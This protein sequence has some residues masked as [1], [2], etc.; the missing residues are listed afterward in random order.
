MNVDK[1][2][3]LQAVIAV[4]PHTRMSDSEGFNMKDYLHDCGTPSCLAGFACKVN[5]IY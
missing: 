4:Q 5:D 3:A 1:I 2:K